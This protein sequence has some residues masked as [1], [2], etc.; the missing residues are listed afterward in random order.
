MLNKGKA[1]ALSQIYV[2]DELNLVLDDWTF[3]AFISL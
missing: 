2:S 3:H 1:R